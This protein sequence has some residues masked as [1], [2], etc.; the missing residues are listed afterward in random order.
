[1]DVD[2][3]LDGLRHR[4]ALVLTALEHR[5]DASAPSIPLGRRLLLIR[6]LGL[7][8]SMTRLERRGYLRSGWSID[9]AGVH[10]ELTELG[11][12]VAGAA[13]ILVFADTDAG[14]IRA[15]FGRYRA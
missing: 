15:W 13:A 4:D 1:M 2:A 3:E 12:R 7:R 14:W 11:R 6:V 5:P 10:F 8:R 9:G